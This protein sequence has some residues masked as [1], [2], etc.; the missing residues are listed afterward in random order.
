MVIFGSMPIPWPFRK[1]DPSA[2]A[3]RHA[4]EAVAT[5]VDEVRIK[6]HQRVRAALALLD[7]GFGRPRLEAEKETYQQQLK[8]LSDAEPGAGIDILRR[9]IAGEKILPEF[10]GHGRG[11]RRRG[12]RGRR[13]GGGSAAAGAESGTGQTPEAGAESQAQT[14]Q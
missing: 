14:P 4:R 10:P 6:G 13:R 12:R 3:Q 9:H 11:R 1:Y 2:L 5:L 7:R 8:S